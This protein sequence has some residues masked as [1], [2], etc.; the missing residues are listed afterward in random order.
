[1]NENSQQSWSARSL[2]RGP[3]GV[4]KRR[5]HSGP[6]SPGHGDGKFE[7]WTP[8]KKPEGP[9]SC[10][11][12]ADSREQHFFMDFGG[13]NVG[14]IEAATGKLTLFRRRRPIQT[15][16]GRMDEQDRVWF[17]EWRPKI[18]MFDTK[19]EKFKEW[20]VPRLYR[21]LR[22]RPRPGTARCGRR[23]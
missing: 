15:A 12:Y 14:K 21:A 1:V 16:P 4:L 11:D 2:D 22:R 6:A 23:A 10:T 20:N 18:G 17:A 9:H 3:Q 5:R 7:T 19:T 13:E 8:Y